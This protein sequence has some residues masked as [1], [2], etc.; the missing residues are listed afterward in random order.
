VVIAGGVSQTVT[1]KNINLDASQSTDPNGLALTYQ[2]SVTGGEQNVSLLHGT[3]AVA[4]AQLGDNGPN[5]YVFTVTVT[6]SA[7]KSTTVTVTI[8]YVG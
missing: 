6:N 7:G 3:S 4:S 1:T 8:N 5:T 2:W